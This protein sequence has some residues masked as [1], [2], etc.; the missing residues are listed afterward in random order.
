M[1]LVL[2]VGRRNRLCWTCPGFFTNREGRGSKGGGGI[3]GLNAG[4][5]LSDDCGLLGGEG[6]LLGV[7]GDLDIGGQGEAE[8]GR[9]GGGHKSEPEDDCIEGWIGAG[10]DGMTGV[11]A[12]SEGLAG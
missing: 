5:I 6:G 1:T 10:G 11:E 9:S 3:C 12:E 2:G 8:G 4:C 7:W